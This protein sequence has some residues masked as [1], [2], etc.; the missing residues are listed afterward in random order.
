MTFGPRCFTCVT[1]IILLAG[2]CDSSPPSVGPRVPSFDATSAAPSNDA[3]A[4]AAPIATLPFSDATDILAAGLEP[5]EP[6]PSCGFGGTDR[7]I[8]YSFTPTTTMWIRASVT[9]APFQAIIALYAGSSLAT[10]SEVACRG[11][12]EG[13][14]V[15]QVQGGT[16]YFFQVGGLFGGGGPLEFQVAEVLP[17]PNDNVADAVV[18]GALPFADAVD[19]AAASR[20]VDEPIAPCASGAAR[21]VW[22]RFTPTETRSISAFTINAGAPVVVAAYRGNTFADFESLGCSLFGGAVTFRAETGTTYVFQMESPFVPDFPLGF[23]LEVTPPPNADFAYGP[24]LDPS[25][26]D[27]VN[28]FNFSSDPGG[29]GFASADWR[30]GDGGTAT[31]FVVSHQYASDGD[32]PVEI[33]VT[34]FDGRVGSTTRNVSIR[35]H[36]VAVTKLLVPQ[37]V[38]AG[39]TR[40]IVVGVNNNRYD[41]TV[42]TVLSKSGPGGFEF[43][44]SLTKPVPAQPAN[45]TTNVEFDYTFT[46]ADAL[47]GKVTFRVLAFVTSARDA[48]PSDNEVIAL[49][50]RVR[51]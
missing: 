42:E 3:F 48:L 14:M 38:S 51:K 16:T 43:V 19:V 40:R 4:N 32:Y 12:F 45:R 5:G 35:T 22:Y 36:D 2:A 10:V 46:A 41:E 37:T 24:F 50:T 20:E 44:T 18:I 26:F 13:R 49:P 11:A 1:A 25:V 17:P 33:T 15:F 6:A 8:W 30:F 9:N 23:R 34:T 27:V 21:T 39:Q 31:G 28:F 29:L 7:T 47:A